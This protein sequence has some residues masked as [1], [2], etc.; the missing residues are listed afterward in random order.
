MPPHELLCQLIHYFRRIYPWGI[1]YFYLFT[2]RNVGRLVQTSSIAY[3]ALIYVDL[4]QDVDSYL[5]KHFGFSVFNTVRDVYIRH[6]HD[7]SETAFT[8]RERILRRIMLDYVPI[9]IPFVTSLCNLTRR[10]GGLVYRVFFCINCAMTACYLVRFTNNMTKRF[11]G[12]SVW[13]LKAV[14]G[15][16]PE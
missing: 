8:M 16:Y 9:L 1:F 11:F 5:E 3:L 15:R 6:V 4:S 13:S 7:A 2:D 14:E 10:D 12:F